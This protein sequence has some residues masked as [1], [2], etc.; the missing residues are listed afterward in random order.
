MKIT[1][2]WASLE[3]N[4]ESSL[5]SSTLGNFAQDHEG[6]SDALVVREI[7]NLY[8]L[9]IKVER[10]TRRN[11]NRMEVINRLEATNK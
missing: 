8:H 2:Q 1:M 7:T 3:T 10:A 11:F 6:F 9:F 5:E 4:F